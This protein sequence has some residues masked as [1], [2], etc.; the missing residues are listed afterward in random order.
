MNNPFLVRFSKGL[1]IAGFI[2]GVLL[3][4]VYYF[5]RDK[6]AGLLAFFY[7]QFA[8]LIALLLV[9]LLVFHLPGSPLRRKKLLGALAFV[10]SSY[11]LLWLITWL[12][13]GG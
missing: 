1:S 6:E 2:I 12:V 3:C 8:G 13:T 4:A 5:D 10:I 11:A 7:L 9:L